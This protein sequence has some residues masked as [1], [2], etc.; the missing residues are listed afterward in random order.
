MPRP[1]QWQDGNLVL[2]IRVQPRASADGIAVQGDELKV[3]ITA[4]PVEGKA[5]EH[6]LRFLAKTF[7]VA[8]SNVELIGGAGAR[9]KRIRILSP[10]RLPAA[11]K[12]TR[13]RARHC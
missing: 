11:L 5:N 9:H 3:R 1:W 8:K 7:G 2:S 6:L 4:A 13:D 10:T 12:E